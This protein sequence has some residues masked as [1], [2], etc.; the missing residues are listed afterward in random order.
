VSNVTDLFWYASDSVFGDG[1][2]TLTTLITATMNG[3]VT[4]RS[5]HSLKIRRRYCSQRFFS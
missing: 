3:A 2:L 4:N 1:H 5:G